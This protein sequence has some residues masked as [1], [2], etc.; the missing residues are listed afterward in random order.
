[1]LKSIVLVLTLGVATA[2][3][4]APAGGTAA[5]TRTDPNIIRRSELTEAQLRDFTVYEVIQQLRPRML[6]NLGPTSV[7]PD[8]GALQV[9]LESTRL[10]DANALKDIRMVEIE[11]IRY[12]SPSE[13]T[14]RYGTG[15]SNG[16]VQLRR[17]RR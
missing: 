8:G 1:M 9:Y 12:L 5:A 17:L 6:A 2:C 3:A 11:E 15:H 14:L 13:A 4:S 7:G 16:V 10:G